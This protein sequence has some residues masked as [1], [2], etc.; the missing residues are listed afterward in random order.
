M[1]QVTYGEAAAP[2]WK[3]LYRVGGWAALLAAIVIRRNLSAEV[4]LFGSSRLPP[5]PVD[6]AGW[7]AL[8]RSNRLLGLTLLDVF[9]PVNYAL[10]ALLILALA[11]ALRR[12][13]PAAGI[14][15]AV[16][17]IGAVVVSFASNRALPMLALSGRYAAASGAERA[18]VLAAGD[19]LLAAPKTGAH[20][21]LLLVALAGLILSLAMLR[22]GTF[23]RATALVGIAAHGILLG[24]FPVLAFAPGLLALPHS[25]AA[26]FIVAWQIMAGLRLLRLGRSGG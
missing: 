5:M 3:G 22:S 25:L 10:V 4:K 2:G 11:A 7:F 17:G 26:P 6:A 12:E 15:A 20:V 19:V 9:D 23:N 13:K 16:C 24:V 21:A 1:A 14:V 8:L 18:A